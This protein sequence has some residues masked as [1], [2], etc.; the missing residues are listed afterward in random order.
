M[1]DT[2]KQVEGAVDYFTQEKKRLQE[3]LLDL[4]E[5][6]DS[7][8]HPEYGNSVE[9]EILSVAKKIAIRDNII[10]QLKSIL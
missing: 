8:P 6:L 4:I 9:M 1:E 7:I 5:D 10:T 2:R 3:T